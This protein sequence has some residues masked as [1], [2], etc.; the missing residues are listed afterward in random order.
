MDRTVLVRWRWRLRGA[1]MWKTFVALIAVDAAIGHALP[2]LGDSQSVVGAAL[3][4]SFLGLAAIVL[5][6]WPAML[7]IRRFRK[8]LPKVIARDYGGTTALLAVTVGLLVAGIVHHGT[9]AA[10]R[11]ALQDATAQAQAYV[12]DHAPAQ[13]RSNLQAV[14]VFEVQP[15]RFYRV[16]VFNKTDTRNYCVVV[17]RD[18]PFGQSVRFDGY[19]PNGI[20]DQGAN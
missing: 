6:S 11:S 10:D 2:P 3:V 1:W 8:D 18:K 4:G 15:P 16:C 13:F 17:D 12:G 9:L 20:L 19:E 5:L 7:I 14:N